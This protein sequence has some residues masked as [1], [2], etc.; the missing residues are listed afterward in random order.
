V[1]EATLPARP[2]TPRALR[3]PGG[4]GRWNAGLI[5]G[6]TLWLSV[7]VLLPLAAVAS[8]AFD[9]GLSGFWHAATAP[10]AKSALQLTLELSAAAAIVNAVAGTAIAWVLVR[11]SFRGK[12]IVEGL[13]DLPFALPTIVAGLT[14]LALYGTRA[15]LGVDI[16]YTRW[17]IF[18]ALLF[19]TLPFGVRA[20]Q[21]VLLE[22]DPDTEAAA[23]SLGARP[24]T[25]VRRI[26]LPAL[27]PA[28]L[29]GMALAFARALGEFGAITL[30]AGNQ[31]FRTEYASV[32]ISNQIESGAQSAAAAVSVVLLVLSLIALL[33]L[34]AG[35]RRA[36]RH[37][38]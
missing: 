33:L 30:I 10:E 25:I 9:N 1:A 15:P 34:E 7:I 27:R 18:V 8:S 5:G 26:I 16:A 12:R 21:P 3:R 22:L 4:L 17:G 35:E 32:F 38:G 2:S 11:D 37:V 13:V 24:A 20:V 6:T 29:S 19:V 23:A 14:L 36:S 28:I 31:P